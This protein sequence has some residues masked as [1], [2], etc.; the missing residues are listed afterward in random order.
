[1]DISIITIVMSSQPCEKSLKTCEGEP[2]GEPYTFLRNEIC[3]GNRYKAH[4]MFYVYF[5]QH[6]R[7]FSYEIPYKNNL[8]C[9]EECSVSNKT[10]DLV[11]VFTGADCHHLS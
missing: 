9:E 7:R 8:C 6:S 5:I 3:I 4:R 11:P 10:I 1:M 2:L